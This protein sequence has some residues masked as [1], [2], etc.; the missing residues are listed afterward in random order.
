MWQD[1]HHPYPDA[2]VDIDYAE[3]SEE[4]LA[5]ELP[6]G[7]DAEEAIREQ[8]HLVNVA[9]GGLSGVLVQIADQLG[10]AES[11]IMLFPGQPHAIII[12]V[13]MSDVSVLGK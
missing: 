4:V 3:L 9:L 8:T 5:K 6:E 12:S 13:T 10:D 2:D 11:V 1:S 7:T